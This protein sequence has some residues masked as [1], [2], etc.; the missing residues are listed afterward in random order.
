MSYFGTG[1]RVPEDLELCS[2]EGYVERLLT[3]PAPAAP[4]GP[5]VPAGHFV[6]RGGGSSQFDALVS[7]N[8][9]TGP[10]VNLT[11]Y[12]EGT[13]RAIRGQVFGLTVDVAVNGN[14][15]NGLV[16]STPLDIT[17]TRVEEKL[18][19]EGV[20]RGA[21]S[22]FDFSPEVLDGKIG[23]CTY[24]L[25]QTGKPSYMGSR[26]CGGGI[27][28]SG[29]VSAADAA[30]AAGDGWIAGTIQ[31][32]EDQAGKWEI[33]NLPKL[34]GIDGATNFSANGGSSWAISKTGDFRTL[35]PIRYSLCVQ[36]AYLE[37]YES[38]LEHAQMISKNPIHQHLVQGSKLLL[39]LPMTEELPSLEGV[40]GDAFSVMAHILVDFQKLKQAIE[41][42]GNREDVEELAKKV[43]GYTI[44]VDLHIPMAAIIGICLQALT[45]SLAGD[46]KTARTVLEQTRN[47]ISGTENLPVYAQYYADVIK[48]DLMYKESE[49]AVV[50][51]E[52]SLKYHLQKS[53][54]FRRFL[55]V[56]CPHLVYAMH[57]DRPSELTEDMIKN[58]IVVSESGIFV[59]EKELGPLPKVE[60]LRQAMEN[61]Y[62]GDPMEKE[63]REIL[64]EYASKIEGVDHDGVVVEWRL[65]GSV[66]LDLEG[67]K[68]EAKI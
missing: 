18:H 23:N 7:G 2:A 48:A 5:Q 13:D 28:S 34:D 68:Q 3:Q 1:Q 67:K 40:E 36:Y 16:G 6:H 50:F 47:L 56:T 42:C 21:P 59:G 63:D 51:M 49:D 11:R 26:G 65:D 41:V 35:D 58:I 33:T 10:T 37:D 29:H 61:W 43:L 38:V 55:V 44:A 22:D 12:V 9:I 32:A 27:A 54:V 15:A 60:W 52:A 4:T 14:K 53:K 39:G 8:D 45:Y 19:V 24:H 31:T 25:K 17:A 46:L 64:R 62:E 66:E 30:T 57:E 20:I